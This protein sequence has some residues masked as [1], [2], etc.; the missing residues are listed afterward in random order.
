MKDP[1]QIGLFGGKSKKRINTAPTPTI[2][3][4]RDWGE[5]LSRTAVHGRGSC[6]VKVVKKN[7]EK[8]NVRARIA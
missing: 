7:S 1:E 3:I 6:A 4:T 8:R 5:G 2:S